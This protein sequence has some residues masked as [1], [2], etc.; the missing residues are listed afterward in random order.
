MTIIEQAGV[1]VVLRGRTP[2]ATLYYQAIIRQM[3]TF[4]AQLA[5]D[6]GVERA[7]L[8]EAL[9]DFAQWSSRVESAEGLDFAFAQP[10]DDAAAIQQKFAAYLD[11][12]HEDLVEQVRATIQTMDAPSNPTLAP[13][14]MLD[15]DAKK[16]STG[17]S[18]PPS[19]S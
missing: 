19:S 7:V 12:V 17:S 13:L 11:T 16:K 1:R 9:S 2:R 14:N 5:D 18:A 8:D 3:A 6:L 15:E 10:G 4:Y